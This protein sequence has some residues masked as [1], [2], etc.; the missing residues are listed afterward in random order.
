MVFFV[1]LVINVPSFSVVSLS[2]IF[3]I[4]VV[5]SSIVFSYALPFIRIL[6]SVHLSTAFLPTSSSS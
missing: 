1:S 6:T 2:H 5:N 4:F 3:Y